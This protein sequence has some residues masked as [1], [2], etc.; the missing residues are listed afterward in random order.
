MPETSPPK[1]KRLTIELHP[2]L[3]REFMAWCRKNGHITRSFVENLIV[4]ALAQSG[5]FTEDQVRELYTYVLGERR[6][7]GD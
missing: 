6:G 4:S 5:D 2:D 3:H 1:L 7:G